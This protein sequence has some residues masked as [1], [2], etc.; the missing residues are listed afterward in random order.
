[1]NLRWASYLFYGSPGTIILSKFVSPC[2]WKNSLRNFF[3][4]NNTSWS[5]SN[6]TTAILGGIVSTV[7]SLPSESLSHLFRFLII[8]K[9][10]RLLAIIF[11]HSFLVPYKLDKLYISDFIVHLSN[12]WS[13]CS[14]LLQNIPIPF[15]YKYIPYSSLGYL[16]SNSSNLL[17]LSHSIK[18]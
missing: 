6:I 5:T 17:N 4:F 12:S 13:F 9:S 3:L 1:M 11:R 15:P 16:S 10:A 2:L 14:I 8:V 7:T 18:L